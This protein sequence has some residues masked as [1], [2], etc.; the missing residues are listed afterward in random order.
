MI[1]LGEKMCGNG[2]RWE[3]PAR[4]RRS[5]HSFCGPRVGGMSHCNVIRLDSWTKSSDLFQTGWAHGLHWKLVLWRSLN[6]TVGR[7]GRPVACYY[8]R[9]GTNGIS[10]QPGRGQMVLGWL[11][12]WLECATN[13]VWVLLSLPALATELR[14]KQ[15][16]VLI[17]RCKMCWWKVGIMYNV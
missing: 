3:G 11:S 14:N 17:L 10:T 16:L 5:Q 15:D 9:Y 13:T 1:A 2:W 7:G 4:P 8:A 12:W 6:F